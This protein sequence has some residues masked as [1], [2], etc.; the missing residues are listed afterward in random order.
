ML[1]S[2]VS[3]FNSHTRFADF[4]AIGKEGA[5]GTCNRTAWLCADCSL[6]ICISS[7]ASEGG[8]EQPGCQRS[9]LSASRQTHTLLPKYGATGGLS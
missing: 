5:E 7:S 9:N 1:E 2:R 4:K 8:W 3:L 6:S